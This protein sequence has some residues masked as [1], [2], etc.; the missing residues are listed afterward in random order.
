MLYRNGIGFLGIQEETALLHAVWK[1]GAR[2]PSMGP[3]IE[4]K[5]GVLV[6]FL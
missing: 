3:I 4:T 5:K 6:W 1:E 2:R